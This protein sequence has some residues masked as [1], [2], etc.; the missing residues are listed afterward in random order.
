MGW[1]PDNSIAGKQQSKIH[2]FLQRLIRNRGIAGAQDYVFNEIKPIGKISP[3]LKI[4]FLSQ[5]VLCFRPNPF[6]T[7]PLIFRRQFYYRMRQIDARNCEI[8]EIPCN[9]VFFIFLAKKELNLRIKRW[10]SAGLDQMLLNSRMQQIL[11][12]IG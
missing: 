11:L 5:T 4:C 6:C 1:V 3:G 7:L 9:D 12:K 8:A 10:V 2:L